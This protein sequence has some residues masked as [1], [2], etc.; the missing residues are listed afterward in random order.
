[1]DLNIFADSDPIQPYEV[2]VLEYVIIDKMN[3]LILPRDIHRLILSSLDL[4]TYY[5][6]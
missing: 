2:S 5:A 1:M 3:L 6:D 4:L